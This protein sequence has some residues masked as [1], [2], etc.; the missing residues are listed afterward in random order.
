MDF[1]ELVRQDIAAIDAVHPPSSY[2]LHRGECL[3][4][5]I[6]KYL[7][8]RGIKAGTYG[9]T[10]PDN[11]W[12]G[13]EQEPYPA[14]LLSKKED[15]PGSR[16]FIKAYQK[17][18]FVVGGSTGKR[19]PVEVKERR[20]HAGRSIFDYPTIL[21]GKVENWELKN[22][23]SADKPGC[24]QVLAIVI[25]CGFTGEIRV[26]GCGLA[27]QKKWIAIKR[28]HELSYEVP[29][30]LFHPFDLFARYIKTI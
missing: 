8:D 2:G 15:F 18:L 21:V 10:F 4:R 22:L 26:A 30:P 13:F 16:A 20:H 23:L 6:P 7:G 24:K 29:T 25:I 12:N 11:R 27:H 19:Y 17:D 9:Q 14:T 1:S 28:G 5:L 3:E